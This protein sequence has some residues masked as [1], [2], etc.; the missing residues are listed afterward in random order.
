MQDV[1]LAR[2]ADELYGL[3][4]ADFRAARDERANQARAAGD[5]ELSDAIKKLRRPTMS[6]WMVNRL[7]HEAADEI[8]RLLELGASLREAQQS[9]DGDRLRELSAERRQVVRGLTQEA[10]RLAA[11]TRQPVSDQAEREVEATLEAALADPA[12]ADAVRSGRL[13]TGLVYAGLGGMDIG[14]AVAVPAVPPGR[15]A[16]TGQQA[17]GAVSRAKRQQA[18]HAAR[19]AGERER[20]ETALAGAAAQTAGAEAKAREAAE[21]RV[22]EAAEQGVRDAEAVAREARAALDEAEQQVAEARERY[23][24]IQRRIEDL[25]QR[26][27]QA[28]EE[29][30]RAA[31]AVRDARRSR[32]VAGRSAD[33][34]KRHLAQ[35]Q[36]KLDRIMGHPAGS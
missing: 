32:D 3:A 16:V 15:S 26:L 13:T 12:A 24:E 36:A 4:P 31:R 34:A 9:L 21:R 19:R 18:G 11:E 27:E 8:G 29:E 6:A 20:Q 33:T 1:N 7:V 22:R 14:D 23:E 10:K 25:E 17:R 28:Q 5:R 2:V 35:A 30:T